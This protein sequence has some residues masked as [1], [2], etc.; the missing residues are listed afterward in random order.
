MFSQLICIYLYIIF[1]VVSARR[2]CIVERVPNADTVCV[3][4]STYCDDFPPLQTPKHGFVNVFESNKIGDRFKQ[5]ELKFNSIGLKFGSLNTVNITINKTI[6][7]QSIIGFGAAF[8]D[9]TGQLFKSVN[10]SLANLIIDSYFS[11]DGIEYSI[12]RIPIAG[13][14]YSDRPYSYDDTDE[15][16]E[17]K[18][19]ALQKDDIEFKIPFIK[20]ALSVSPYKLKLLGS[21]WSP[22]SWM[23]TNHKFNE[24]GSLRGDVGGQYYQSF[25][26]YIVKFLEAYKEHDIHLWGITVENEPIQGSTNP[27]HPFNCLNL[28]AQ[29][30]RDFVKLNLGPTLET[31][32]YGKDSGFQLMIYDDDS[33]H[34]QDFVSTI[35]SDTKAAKYVSGI[36]YHWYANLKYPNGFPEFI[37]GDLYRKYGKNYF[38]L[39]TEACHLDGPSLG[40]WDHAERYANDIIRSLN[41]Y[42]NG[43]VE[44]N[45][46]LDMDGGP[47]WNDKQGYGGT[48][49]IDSKI[50]VAYKQPSF[51]A[52]GHF[53]KFISPESIRIEHTIDKSVDNFV[54]VTLVRPDNR[55]VLVALNAGNDDIVLNIKE[56]TN[57]VSH[58]ISSHS[59]QS[60]IW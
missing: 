11:D 49:N 41:N 30:E 47:R 21:P 27:K 26:K 23:K 51:Y 9:S 40:R 15:D 59:V 17:L 48:I 57:T 55:T 46:A 18:H 31:A 28:T 33:D 7:Y 6:K 58:I 42:V 12:G 34:I 36:G 45:L 35:L 60:Y 16:L 37:I 22:P 38:L 52:L 56:S 13:T 24:S 44:W 1:Y 3:C 29:N 25:A 2:E 39:N 32:G 10:K 43:W 50:G 5:S 19:F 4:N 14:D 20:R 53:S 8:T 54:V